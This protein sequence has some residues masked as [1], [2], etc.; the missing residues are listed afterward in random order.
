MAPITMEAQNNDLDVRFESFAVTAPT[1]LSDDGLRGG[2]GIRTHT[3]WGTD[4][5]EGP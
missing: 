5:L 4:T 2:I 3:Q 1:T